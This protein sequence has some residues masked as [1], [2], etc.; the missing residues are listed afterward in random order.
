[1]YLPWIGFFHKL[2]GSDQFVILDSVKYSRNN[3]FNRNRVKT[4]RGSAWLTVPIRRTDLNIAMEK[5]RIDNSSVWREKHMN[6]MTANY[7]NAPFYDY[8]SKMLFEP[9]N[10]EWESLVDLNIAFLKDISQLLRINRVT[11]R[12][13]QLDV[14]GTRTALIVDICKTLGADTYLSG[15]GAREYLEEDKLAKAGISLVYQTFHHPVYPQLHGPFLKNLSIVDL[16]FNCGPG[17]PTLIGGNE[18]CSSR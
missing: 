3:F 8:C 1:M 7:Q 6:I 14:K 13:S 10:Q 17:S 12:S 15:L 11:Y 5:V 9:L 18:S 2:K 16:I 4:P